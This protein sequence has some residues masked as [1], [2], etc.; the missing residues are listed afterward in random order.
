M[1]QK[2]VV[3]EDN[4]QVHV[5]NVYDIDKSHSL[6]TGYQGVMLF[7]YSTLF[8]SINIPTVLLLLLI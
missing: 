5:K 3:I 4:N 2:C 8:L 7:H 1:L 6:S